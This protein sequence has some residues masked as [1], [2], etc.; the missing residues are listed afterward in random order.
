VFET[1][2]TR[3][4][5]KSI[6]LHLSICKASHGTCTTNTWPCS[7]HYHSWQQHSYKFSYSGECRSGNET[8]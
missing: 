8:V 4:L 3:V 6:L 5:L 7:M 2:L 1:E